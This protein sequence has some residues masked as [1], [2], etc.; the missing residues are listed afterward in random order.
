MEPSKGE[1]RTFS[2]SSC[3]SAPRDLLQLLQFSKWEKGEG[4]AGDCGCP[5]GS[6]A[7]L[8]A[9]SCQQLVHSLSSAGLRHHRELAL[10]LSVFLA[11][12]LRLCSENACKDVL[13]VLR[14]EGE[15]KRSH[16]L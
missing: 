3:L 13:S 5:H 14:R 15:R 9:S 10:Y 1:Q 4:S 11:K 2:A 12:G 16:A 7:A 6:G 8:R